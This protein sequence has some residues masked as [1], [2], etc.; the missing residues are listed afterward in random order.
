MPVV[1]VLVEVSNVGADTLVLTVTAKSA[2]RSLLEPFKLATVVR[3]YV[4]SLRA[5]FSVCSHSPWALAV[6]TVVGLPRSLSGVAELP[7]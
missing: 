6:T 4:P 1:T 5:W 7:T 3:L 2:E